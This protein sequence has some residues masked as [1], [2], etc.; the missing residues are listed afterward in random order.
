[1]T[2]LGLRHSLLTRY[3]SF[4]AVYELLRN[5]EGEA[6]DVRQPLPLPEGV[7]NHAVG[8]GDEPPLT[9]LAAALALAASLGWLLRRTGVVG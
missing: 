1:M 6:A 9:L 4:V 7:S 5:P 8:I 2:E 3:T